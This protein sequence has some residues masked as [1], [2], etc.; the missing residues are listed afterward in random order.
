VSPCLQ[1]DADNGQKR[2]TV[3]PATQMA[4]GFAM[5]RPLMA[6]SCDTASVDCARQATP[7]LDGT[8]C[9]RVPRVSDDWFS[10]Y[11]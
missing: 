3:P 7:Y 5:S 11:A 6:Y 4:T 8:L 9:N 1:H 2:S 10:R